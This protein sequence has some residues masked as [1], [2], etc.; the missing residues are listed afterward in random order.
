M[1]QKL[2][3]LTGCSGG[4]KSTLLQALGERGHATVSEPG[5]RIVVDELAR[6]SHALPWVNMHA[7][8]SRAIEVARSDL[9]AARELE[10][11]VFFDRGLVD[12]AVA[13]A[14]SGG[15]DLSE[16]L[17]KSRQYAK[18][19]FVAP[20]WKELFTQDGE[21]RHDFCA[22]VQEYH[23]ILCALDTLGYLRTE[24]PRVSVQQRVEFVLSICGAA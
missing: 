9:H 18:Q 17:G 1:R 3:L 12:A 22:A 20:P 15:Q 13:L 2:I 16:T 21:R 6:S 4:G 5:R 24:L 10:G 7:F 8:A 23:R 19:V 11:S 14:S